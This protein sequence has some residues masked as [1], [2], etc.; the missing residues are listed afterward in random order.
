MHRTWHVPLEAVSRLTCPPI[1]CRF[2]LPRQNPAFGKF[3][4]RD[5]LQTDGLWDVYNDFAMGNCG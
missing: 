2:L 5:S 1:E 3:E 4:A